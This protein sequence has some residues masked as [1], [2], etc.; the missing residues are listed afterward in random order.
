MFNGRNTG[1][2]LK[3]CLIVKQAF[4]IIHILTGENPLAVFIDAVK[5]GGPREDS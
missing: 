4:E 1:K 5:L 2:K 3:A